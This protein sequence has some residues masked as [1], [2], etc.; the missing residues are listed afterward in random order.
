[1]KSCA[2]AAFAAA[3]TSSSLAVGAAVADVLHRVGREDDA[4]LRDDADA[5]AQG[6]ERDP[7]DALAVDHHGARLDVVEAQ[8][9]LQHRA[10]AGA[11]RADQGDRLAGRDGEAEV[12]Q[13]R[14][15][16]PR[17]IAEGD[18]VELH[19]GAAGGRRQRPRRRRRD[20]RRLQLQ[21]LHQ[22][23]G[24]AGGAQQ[25][26]VD[27]GEHGDAAHQ[28]DHV[29]DGLAEVAGADVA[30]H[31]RLRALI[32]APE[33]RAEGR[34]DDEGDQE[35]AHLRPPHGGAEGALGRGAETVGLAPFL[36][37]ALHHR[38]GVQHLGG[39]R[40]RVGDPVLAGAR[41]A[42]HA[43]AEIERRQDDQDQDRQ[44]LRHDD[45]VGDD[46]H[47]HRA[48]AH[49]GVA[50][51]HRQARA[52]DGLH[53]RRVGRQAR[54]H[55]AGLRRLEELGALADDVRVDGVA[56]VGGDALAEPAHH[57]EARR[58]E[59]AEGDADREQGEEVLAQRHHARARDR[60]R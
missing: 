9:Q 1:M 36:Q 59:D 22:P 19:R 42:A 39:D 52:D 14:M 23:L 46:Q 33:Q 8:D 50:Q 10:L 47:R 32:E 30:A 51:P 56:Q 25:V 5:A 28:D 31:D 49:H 55:L 48:D 53:Q 34:A 4:V 2:N 44:H 57:V 13:R 38:H 26:A 45:R 27:L 24:R 60:R 12:G 54:Q 11:A 18:V 7:V 16:R 29:D 15:L 41:Q 17:R 58:R 3:T 6:L 43:A 40:A 35:R 37:V 21:Q 20:D